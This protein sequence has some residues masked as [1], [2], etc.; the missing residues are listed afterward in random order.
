MNPATKNFTIPNCNADANDIY[1]IVQTAHAEAK[2]AATEFF[3]EKLDGVD[4]YSCG[5]AWVT[6]YGV[7]GK[8]IR[9]NSKLSQ[10]FARAG[11]DRDWRNNLQIWNPS[12][13][14]VQNVDTLLAGAEAAA[15]VLRDAGFEAYAGSR[16]D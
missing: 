12:R 4:Q 5:F 3:N 9:R 8:K 10:A 1:T 16:L 7:N 6:I 2:K 11:V 14:P 13:L 15:K